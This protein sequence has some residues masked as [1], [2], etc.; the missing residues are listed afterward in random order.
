MADCYHSDAHWIT[1]VGHH[2]RGR[3]EIREGISGVV[4]EMEFLVQMQH[5]IVIEDLTLSTAT[6]RSVLNEV[7][8]R[9]GGEQGVFVLG[10]Y[11]DEVTKVD[12][13]WRFKTRYFQNHYLDLSPMPGAVLVNYYAQI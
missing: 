7:G 3:D 4:A 9:P 2:F 10:V 6:A 11:T 5:A 8:R 1:S 13:V 12:G